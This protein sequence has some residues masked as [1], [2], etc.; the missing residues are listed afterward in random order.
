MQARM[1]SPIIMARPFKANSGV[2][3]RGI[4]MARLTMIPQTERITP[5]SAQV[6][7]LDI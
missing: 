3:N 1:L 6:I 4:P 2:P 7:K 5:T